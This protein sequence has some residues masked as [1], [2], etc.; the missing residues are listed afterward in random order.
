MKLNAI[1][2][3][4][5]LRNDCL[6]ALLAVTFI[7]I[8]LLTTC[9]ESKSDPNGS[10]GI[11]SDQF[12]ADGNN[13]TEDGNGPTL[14]MSYSKQKFVKNPIASFMYFVPL[15]AP[16]FVDN[17]SSVNNEQHVGIISHKLTV[18]SKSFRVV[19]EFEIL[20]SGFHMNTFDSAGMIAAHTDEFKKGE[21]LT[22][23]LDYIKIE[24]EGYGVIEV[25]GRITGSHRIITEVNMKFNAR[26][27]ESTITIGFYDIKPKEGDYKYEN[28]S[29]EVV[30]RVNTLNFKK[31][32][33]T[34]KMGIEIASIAKKGKSAGLFGWIKGKIANLLI[35]PL[36]VTK[37]GN[38][39]MLEF[40]EA[41][42][43]KK[44]TFTFPEA[45]NIKESKVVE[46]DPIQK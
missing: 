42:V 21:T 27:H 6:I 10:I 37:L 26:G 36:K 30:A 38:T 23:M 13:I 25:K 8:F 33:Q 24:R 29:N 11:H 7:C 44:P 17:I 14:I 40:G 18:Q 19:C 12:A 3:R 9:D 5:L 4:V 22:N 16:T 43:Q 35:E 32:E 28:R 41:L 39:T 2:L 34:P 31:T 1:N 20:G 15:I 45:R 46:V